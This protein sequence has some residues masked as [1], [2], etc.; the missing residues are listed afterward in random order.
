MGCARDQNGNHVIHKCI[1]C[2][3]MEKIGF[4]ISTFRGQVAT[5][6]THPYGCHVIKRVLEHCSDV[7]V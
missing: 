6:C 1:K 4:I 5:L 7:N 3:P 2:V